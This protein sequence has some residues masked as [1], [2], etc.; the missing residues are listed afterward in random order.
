V[1]TAALTLKALGR[2]AVD[3]FIKLAVNKRVNSVV[4]LDFKIKSSCYGY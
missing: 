2:V 1:L 4:L 3:V